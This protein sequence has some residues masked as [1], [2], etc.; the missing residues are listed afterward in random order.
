MNVNAAVCLLDYLV[1]L[2]HLSIFFMAMEF[3][4]LVFV[5]PRFS[6]PFLGFSLFRHSPDI[7]THHAVVV[8]RRCWQSVPADQG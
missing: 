5:A 1:H 4:S 7:Q 2:S 3:Y 6:V 8:L